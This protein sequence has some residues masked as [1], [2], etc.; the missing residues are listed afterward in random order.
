MATDA[1]SSGS[2]STRR[3]KRR[4]PHLVGVG[5]GATRTLAKAG[6]TLAKNQSKRAVRA[7]RLAVF[8]ATPQNI[9]LLP[10]ED[11]WGVGPQFARRL[12]QEGVHTAADLAALPADHVRSR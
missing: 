5:L 12:G 2:Q 1:C 3:A 8:H 10:V 11:V 4:Q 9:H 6:N 7:G